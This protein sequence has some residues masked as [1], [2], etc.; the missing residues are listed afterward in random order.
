M[1][2]TKEGSSKTVNCFVNKIDAA[3]SQV[4]LCDS[5]HS[6]SCKF[7]G[8]LAKKQLAAFVRDQTEDINILGMLGR[9][10]ELREACMRI[11][12]KKDIDALTHQSQVKVK[13]R[14]NVYDFE[15][16]KT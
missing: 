14:L 12:L 4:E 11:I 13:L 5:T 9:Q 15:V 1:I 16:L 6:I 8:E 2:A 3:Q 10:L 7:V